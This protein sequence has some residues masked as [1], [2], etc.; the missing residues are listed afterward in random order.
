MEKHKSQ[1]VTAMEKQILLTLI[2]KAID[3]EWAR[4]T[5]NILNVCLK[6]W[7]QLLLKLIFRGNIEDLS[8]KLVWTRVY[9]LENH[10]PI[11][12]PPNFTHYCFCLLYKDSFILYV[13]LNGPLFMEVFKFISTMSHLVSAHNYCTVMSSITQ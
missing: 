5:W 4:P 11:S 3:K 6:P 7:I 10:S 2:T 12:H 8:H 9:A 13:F 1:F